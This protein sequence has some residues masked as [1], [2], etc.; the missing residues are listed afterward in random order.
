MQHQQ[1]GLG[2]L[3]EMPTVDPPNNWRSPYLRKPVPNDPWGRPYVYLAP[4][5][6]NPTGY[7]L[8]SYGAD[9]QPGGTG[10]DTDITSWQ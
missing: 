4:G 5:E 8:I 10:E 6:A 3:W 2:A 1:Q 9:G 7:D